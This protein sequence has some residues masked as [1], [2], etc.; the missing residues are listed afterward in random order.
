MKLS[1][2]IPTLNEE[3]VI[4]STIANLNRLT[5]PHEIIISDGHSTDATVTIAR[6]HG[7][8]VVE[9]TGLERQTIAAGR[10]A[11]ASISQ[12]EVLVFM[13]ADTTVSDPNA[14][15]SHVLSRFAH[16]QHLVGLVGKVQVYPHPTI[17]D[18]LFFGLVNFAA[19]ITNNL[20]H[21]GQAAGECQI[22][23]RTAFEKIRGYREDLVTREDAD[24]FL[25]LSKIGRTRY[26]PTLVILHPGRRAHVIGWPML[27][28]TFVLNLV[29]FTLFNKAYSKEWKP[30]R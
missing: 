25:R 26:D 15:F 16:D 13:D 7:A 27:L 30:V 5:L 18:K 6:Q 10:N 29:W 22:I 21:Q 1:I 3:K 12:G 4:G 8:H 9:Y 28:W 20:L 17:A 2:I 14:F 23:R 24:M 11:G 19:R